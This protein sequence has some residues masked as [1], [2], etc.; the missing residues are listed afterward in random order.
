MRRMNGRN[1]Y[2]CHF[3][4]HP[5]TRP[6][7]KDR[8]TE[9]GKHA[10]WNYCWDCHVCYAVASGARLKAVKLWQREIGAHKNFY[11]VLIDYQSNNTTISHFKDD[12][13]E[14]TIGGKTYYAQ[15][16]SYRYKKLL[17]FPKTLNQINPKNMMEKIKIY[18]LFS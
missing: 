11:Q 10:R 15:P 13:Y 18:L 3:C 16:K 7:K 4:N 5:C 17:E 1:Q 9:Y 14:F 6:N 8:C 2:L 12:T